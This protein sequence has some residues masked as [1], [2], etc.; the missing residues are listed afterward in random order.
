M[1]YAIMH[2]IAAMIPKRLKKA[3]SDR[4]KMVLALFVEAIIIVTIA[5]AVY[6]ELTGNPAA[7]PGVF[8]SALSGLLTA[9]TFLIV[10]MSLSKGD[11]KKIMGKLDKL[12]SIES[13]LLRIE[14]HLIAGR[15]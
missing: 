8:Y 7:N 5:I 2:K 14:Q 6:N 3:M 12:D 13:I 11:T 10:N 9:M 15:G 1:I 4:E